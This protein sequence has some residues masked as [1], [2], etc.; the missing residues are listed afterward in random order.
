MITINDTTYIFNNL[1]VEN[2]DSI[3]VHFDVSKLE[4]E[5]E[6]LKNQINKNNSDIVNAIIENGN[7]E[8]F[9]PFIS[10][11]A[12][13][14]TGITL[15]VFFLGFLLR[16]ILFFFERKKKRRQIKSFIHFYIKKITAGYNPKIHKAYL[17]FSTNTS[18][19]SGIIL[20]PPKILSNDFLRVLN[21]D[22]TEVFEGFKEKK[23]ISN[24]L[25]QIE[26]LNKLLDEVQQFHQKALTRSNEFRSDL[27]MM[28][29]NY[30]A[31]LA[32]FIEYEKKNTPNYQNS[33]HFIHFNQSVIDFY[34]GIAGT[35]QIEKFRNDI[36]RVNQ[37][38]VVNNNLYLNHHVGIKIADKGKSL[39]Y[40]LTHLEI[41]T[42][43][44]K[45]QYKAFSDMVENSN[46]SILNQI[47]NINWN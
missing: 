27:E 34:N 25:S 38:Y 36:L 16:W 10:N 3:K 18:I 6:L 40:L 26:F 20:T 39:S 21:I 11:D 5:I 35:P 17:D 4:R 44:F 14:T 23:E 41:H 45:S 28:I 12:L 42:A 9:L 19:D 13:A 32:E 31:T 37:A 1:R 33:N 43:E 46:N 8:S 2:P 30:V 22:S 47:G 29:N 7:E 15:L 24:I